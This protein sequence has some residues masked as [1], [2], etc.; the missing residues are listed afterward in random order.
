MMYYLVLVSPA[1][2]LMD[3]FHF[4]VLRTHLSQVIGSVDSVAHVSI[5]TVQ[6]TARQGKEVGSAL[7]TSIIC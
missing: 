2:S 4:D 7:Q 3:A 5:A 6:T 1:S